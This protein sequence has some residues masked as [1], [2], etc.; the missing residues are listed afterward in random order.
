M[1]IQ[2]CG[3]RKGESFKRIVNAFQVEYPEKLLDGR[4]FVQLCEELLRKNAL[5]VFESLLED[6]RVVF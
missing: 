2:P 6:S 4:N 3:A 1:Q 5:T